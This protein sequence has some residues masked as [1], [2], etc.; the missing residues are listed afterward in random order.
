MTGFEQLKT[1]PRQINEIR[2]SRGCSTF[3]NCP[4]Q[5][6]AE[7]FQ[8]FAQ[9]VLSDKSLVKGQA[10][11]CSPLSA[12]MHDQPD[13]HVGV[14]T[15]RIKSLIEPA[16]FVVFDL[17]GFGDPMDFERLLMIVGEVSGFAYETSSSTPELPRARVVLELNRG[18]STN[19]RQRIS[20]KL[21]MAL[22][23]SLGIDVANFDRSVYLGCQPFY[24]P[25]GNPKSYVFDGEPIDVDAYLDEAEDIGSTEVQRIPTA[26]VS[27][28]ETPL[29]VKR[30]SRALSFLSSDVDRSEWMRIVWS[31]AAHGWKCGEGI[32]RDWSR[33][34][35]SRFDEAGFRNVWNSFSPDREPR[36]TATEVYDRAAHLGWQDVVP[37]DQPPAFEF[38]H[39]GSV[40]K[41]PPAISWVV[42][43]VIPE[44]S[45]LFLVGDPKSGKSLIAFDWATC[46]ATGHR[47]RGRQTTQGGVLIL[48]GEGQHGIIR[49]MQ[50]IS[51]YFLRDLLSAP[52]GFSRTG[53][54][55]C[56]E[57]GLAD[58]IEAA[59]NFEHAYGSIRLIIIDTLHRNMGGA[60]EN[61]AADMSRYFDHIDQLRHRFGASVMTV[62]HSGHGAKERARGSSAIMAGVDVLYLMSENKKASNDAKKVVT[63]SCD[64]NKDGEELRDQHF[65]IIPVALP[66]QP[67]QAIPQTSVVLEQHSGDPLI[68]NVQLTEMD[69]VLISALQKTPANDGVYEDS[70]LRAAFVRER[71]A[72][73]PEVKPNTVSQS[74]G[75]TIDQWL[76]ATYLDRAASDGYRLTAKGVELTRRRAIQS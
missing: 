50:A 25:V 71:L 1:A 66:M 61:S 52:I 56:D 32:A 34:A 45:V 58:V 40:M 65:E 28:I 41:D 19:D 5:Y 49:R 48:A 33:Q 44:D 24:T 20:I 69:K 8:A 7:S 60:D 53:G 35:P 39:L 16:R 6:L 51:E 12:G 70:D 17:D 37:E 21:E 10:F 22:K 2:Y 3:D 36:I 27:V 42:E 76:G 15:W 47:W 13:K 29:N 57:K 62:H 73:D 59:E 46:I 18:L 74:F 23:S 72:R 14:R 31:I 30:L 11:I 64:K 26:S 67:G 54:R 9:K 68:A 63:L 75:R 55:L 4:K 38:V 43:G